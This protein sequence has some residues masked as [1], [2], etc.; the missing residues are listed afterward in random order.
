MILLLI[1]GNVFISISV[2]MTIF[3]M[4]SSVSPTV[5]RFCTS[6]DV[7]SHYVSMSIFSQRFVNRR[8]GLHKFVFFRRRRVVPNSCT[9]Q[10][11]YF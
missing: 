5:Y 9:K 10:M 2:T 8:T 6:V 1:N 7:L 11:N 4:P 3:D